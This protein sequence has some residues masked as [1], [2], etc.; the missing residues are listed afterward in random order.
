MR[1]LLVIA[2]TVAIVATVAVGPGATSRAGAITPVRDVSFPQCG[3][4]LPSSARGGVIGVNGGKAFTSNPC[5]SEQLGWSKSLVDPPA[6]YA[7][8]GN[9]GP[10]RA[11][12]WPL[13]QQSPRV[14]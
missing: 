13:G 11:K 5:L 14:C 10:T 1:R 12:K 4:K 3:T 7:N 8:T 2:T 6:F 9:P